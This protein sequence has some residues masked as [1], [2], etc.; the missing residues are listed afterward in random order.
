MHQI[1]VLEQ[2]ALD[3]LRIQQ[4]Q[5]TEQARQCCA[6]VAE[7]EQQLACWVAAAQIVEATQASV[8][9][10]LPPAAIYKPSFELTIWVVSAG[11]VCN[12]MHAE[13]TWEHG[14]L[15]VAS[16]WYFMG[17]VVCM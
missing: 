8:L 17:E 12:V 11:N 13:H 6:L 3:S 9:V 5:Q 4:E 10:W 1:E 2:H 16:G 7:F 14:L 15:A